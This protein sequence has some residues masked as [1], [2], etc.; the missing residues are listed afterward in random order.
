M[1]GPIEMLDLDLS[2]YRF[3]QFIDERFPALLDSGS[4]PEIVET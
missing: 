3:R 1:A 2:R 4:L